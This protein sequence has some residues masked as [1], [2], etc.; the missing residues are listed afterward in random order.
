MKQPCN[1]PG[2]DR[3]FG[4]N[5]KPRFLANQIKRGPLAGLLNDP[6]VQAMGYGRRDAHGERTDE[7]ALV[8]YVAKKM[9]KRFI[10]ESR[11]IPRRWDIGGDCIEIDVVEAGFIYPQAFTTRERPAPS[12]ISVGNAN[13]ISAGTLGCYM[14][15]NTDGST[16]ILSNNH[17]LAR[18]NAAAIG[19]DIVQQA[20]FDGGSSPADDIATLKR[21]VT[22][23]A[24]GNT[25]DG[26]IAEVNNIGDIV[27]RMMNNLTPVAQPDHPAVGLLFAGGCNRTIMNP[28]VNVLNQLNISFPGA[29]AAGGQPIV[30]PTIGMD[31]EKVGRTTE[32]TTST[33]TE[34]DLTVTI[35]YSF[36]NATFDD[37][38]ATMW[39][40]DKGDSGS[41]VCRGGA[42]SSIDNCGCGSASA[43]GTTLQR[44][45]GSDERLAREIRDKYLRHTKIGRWAV[46]LFYQN[47]ERFLERFGK[48]P[49][50]DD[51]LA[52][53]RKLYDKYAD[54]AR[55]A[56][57][58]PEQ[59]N[60][61]VTQT[62]LREAKQALTRAKKYMT[63]QECEVADELYKI[64]NEYLVGKTAQEA[65]AMLQDTKL[66]EELQKLVKRLPTVSTKDLRCE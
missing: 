66:L 4:D 36:G 37:Q 45:V 43:A 9:P 63:K 48:T 2:S 34:I 60:R 1:D 20:M 62:H 17:V 5:A 6:N 15:D 30:Q 25:V 51:D 39:M 28:I 21:F 50:E 31:V 16:C 23:N 27:D 52:F 49:L 57:A 47:E 32:Y 26:A 38:I 64:G 3:W 10:P 35:P 24:T 44:D 40:S 41:L 65:L 58:A 56:A 14:T 8:V 19:E 59:S 33:I 61:K 29:G 13:E 7:P 55:I 18:Q 42:G 54:E 11:L 46:E 53:A 22:I 12:G